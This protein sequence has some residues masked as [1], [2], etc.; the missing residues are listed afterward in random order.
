MK[1]KVSIHLHAEIARAVAKLAKRDAAKI[2]KAQ[3]KWQAALRRAWL[4]EHPGKTVADYEIAGSCAD[5][6]KGEREF[7]KWFAD[8]MAREGGD[9]ERRCF[10]FSKPPVRR[11]RPTA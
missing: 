9:I 1:T 10:N 6:A 11:A 8:W 2:Y 7:H 3:D 4:T 5:T